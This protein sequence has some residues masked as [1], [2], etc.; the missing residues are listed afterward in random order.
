MTNANVGDGDVEKKAKEMARDGRNIT[1]IAKE[2][3]ISWDE[4]RSYTPSFRSAKVRVTN[5]LNKLAN[6]SDPVKREKLAEDTD[7]YVDFLYDAAK[8]LRTQVDGA[9]KA[10]NR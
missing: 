1:A 3:G 2:L 7:R 6:E 10:L 9:R 4:A 8:H 5:R